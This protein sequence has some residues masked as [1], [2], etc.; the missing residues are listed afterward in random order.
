M[1]AKLMARFRDVLGDEI[2]ISP[3]MKV[4]NVKELVKRELMNR[5]ESLNEVLVA[6]GG[7]YVPDDYV[8]GEDDEVVIFPP[9]SGG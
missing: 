5:G 7:S 8:I 2:P 9:V 6:V 3:G 1:K 4:E